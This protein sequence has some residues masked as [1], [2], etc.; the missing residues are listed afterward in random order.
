M[1][2][3]DPATVFSSID[4]QGIICPW[5]GS[6]PWRNGTTNLA[7]AL[8]LVLDARDIDVV[9]RVEQ[10]VAGFCRAL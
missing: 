8:L 6:Q 1:E 9:E 5:P 3:F 7:E 10:V 2:G 4:R